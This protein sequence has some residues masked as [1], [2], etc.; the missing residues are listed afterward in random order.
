MKSKIMIL[1]VLLTMVVGV[2][3]AHAVLPKNYENVVLLATCAQKTDSFKRLLPS[4]QLE[5]ND[6]V[7]PKGKILMIT[8]FNSLAG[9]VDAT[10]TLLIGDY[11]V[12]QIQSPWFGNVGVSTLNV[13]MTTG[14]AVAPGAKLNAAVFGVDQVSIVL[15]GYLMPASERFY[16]NA[17]P[18]APTDR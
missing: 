16:R 14:F 10:I 7:I 4:G 8:E 9:G 12:S 2:P 3:A 6:F 17:S 11:V 18:T 5:S 1:A 15:R 13:N